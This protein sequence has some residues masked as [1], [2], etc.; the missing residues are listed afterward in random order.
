MFRIFIGWDTRFPEPAEVLSY[1][2]HKH[3]TIPV[4][5]RY[6]KLS[7]LGLNRVHD[8]LA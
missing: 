5:I 7:E 1:S 2:L 3:A 4:E 8:P 6:L